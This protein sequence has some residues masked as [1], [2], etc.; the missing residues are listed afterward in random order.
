MSSE[1]AVRRRRISSQA[2]TVLEDKIQKEVSVSRRE[3]IRKFLKLFGYKP[4]HSILQVHVAGYFGREIRPPREIA[5]R[6]RAAAR[7]GGR[8][9]VVVGRTHDPKILTKLIPPKKKQVSSSG[10][11]GYLFQK[12]DKEGKAPDEILPL[13]FTPTSLNYPREWKD[14]YGTRGFLIT[15]HVPSD[16]ARKKNELNR[17]LRRIRPSV[18]VKKEWKFLDELEPFGY[19]S[20]L[21]QENKEIESG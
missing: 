6:E 5:A 14:M 12:K 10:Y 11:M 16:F 4:E 9:F 17:R 20:T 19:D 2:L 18:D 15:M 21:S 13:D 8:T 3:E 1:Q 7:Y